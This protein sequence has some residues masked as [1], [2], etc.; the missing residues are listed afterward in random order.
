MEKGVT[1]VYSPEIPV[2]SGLYDD[3]KPVPAS[4]CL[5]PP[6]AGILMASHIINDFVQHKSEEHKINKIN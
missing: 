6:A 4:S 5:V 1:V 3:G 2:K